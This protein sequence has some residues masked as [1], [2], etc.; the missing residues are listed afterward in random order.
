MSNKSSSSSS[1]ESST[2]TQ[3]LEDI[4]KAIQLNKLS[5]NQSKR[6]IVL[7]KLNEN[8]D[9][10]DKN[11]ILRNRIALKTQQMKQL[12]HHEIEMEIESQ[13]SQFLE[14]S[15]KK[16]MYELDDYGNLV[17]FLLY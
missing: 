17:C 9:D 5:I 11:E 12:K 4:T 16:E 6:Q 1:D 7:P 10:E 14:K 3:S 8:G 13:N 15:K 2:S